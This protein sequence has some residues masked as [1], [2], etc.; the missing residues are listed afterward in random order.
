MPARTG[1]AGGGA[2][3]G[4]GPGGAAV[5]VGSCRP[6]RDGAAV[7]VSPRGAS[8]GRVAIAGSCEAGPGPTTG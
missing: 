5:P 6:G 3:V 8:G 4:Q 1:G 2:A 7:A